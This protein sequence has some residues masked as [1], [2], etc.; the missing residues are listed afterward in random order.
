MPGSP[1]SSPTW[2]C[3]PWAGPRRFNWSARASGSR[4]EALA[5]RSAA[6]RV[7]ELLVRLGPAHL[8]EQE[9]HRVD[10]V[11]RMQELAQDPDPVELLVVH[12]ELLL[13]GSGAVDVQAGK[14]ALLHQLAVEDDLAV[15]G[16]LELLED[17]LVH[18]GAGVHQRGADDGQRPALFGVARGAEEAL[19]LVQR[20]LG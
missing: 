16:P 11:Q 20:A 4:G 8:R 15:S 19:R 12:Q 2:W 6:H 5:A 17:D 18:A 3:W 9:L 14:D 1:A 13:A 10:G 7:Q